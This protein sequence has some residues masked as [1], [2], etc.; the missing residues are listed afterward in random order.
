M[1]VDYRYKW[2]DDLLTKRYDAH[3]ICMQKMKSGIMK[4]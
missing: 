3:G 1:I 4:S 2:S